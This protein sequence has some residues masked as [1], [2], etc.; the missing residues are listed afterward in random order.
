MQFFGNPIQSIPQPS[1]LFYG[2]GAMIKALVLL[3]LFMLVTVGGS[4]FAAWK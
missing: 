4:S 1:R 3:L 2:D